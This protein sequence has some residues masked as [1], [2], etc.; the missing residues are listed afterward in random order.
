MRNINQ[1][2][3][4]SLLCQM[5]APWPKYKVTEKVAG[6]FHAAMMNYNADEIAEA[7]VSALSEPDRNEP[8]TPKEL[9]AHINRSKTLDEQA[10]KRKQI[11]ADAY[12]RHPELMK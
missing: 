7:I 1:A 9:I 4:G 5:W 10:E 3:A 8:P 12:A 2:E 6:L 11:V